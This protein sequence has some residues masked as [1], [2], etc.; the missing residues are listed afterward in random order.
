MLRKVLPILALLVIGGLLVAD[1]SEG[2]VVWEGHRVNPE[3]GAHT[4]IRV[5]SQGK[6]R[7]AAQELTFIGSRDV[8]A[9]I[10]PG[11]QGS[12]SDALAV[13]A[14]HRPGQYVQT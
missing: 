9:D 8:W 4:A 6:E 12:V 1:K 5:L 2:T 10:S 3:G 14:T 13:A 7:F 11:P